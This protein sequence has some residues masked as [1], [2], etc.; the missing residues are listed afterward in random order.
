MGSLK[1]NKRIS[2]QVGIKIE[3]V[4]PL[5]MSQSMNTSEAD[6]KVQSMG[7]NQNKKMLQS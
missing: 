4:K 3:E 6:K 2:K 5:G 7:S 1:I